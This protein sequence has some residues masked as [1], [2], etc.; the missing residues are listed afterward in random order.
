MITPSSFSTAG[1]SLC[2]ACTGNTAPAADAGAFTLYACANCGSWS[3]DALVRGATTSFT[4]SGYFDHASADRPR[5]RD[6]LA[7]TG[8]ARRTLLDVGCGT[9]AF[10]SFART[11]LPASSLAGIELDAE[12]AKLARQANPDAT[13]HVGD[14]AVVSESLSGA[15]DLITLWDVL[16]HVPEPGR[17]I[18]ALAARLAPGGL[19]FVQT[20]HEA[21]LLPRLGRLSYSL[22]GGRFKAGIRRTHDAHHLVFFTQAGLGQ[23]AASGGLAVQSTWFDRLALARMDGSPLLTWP[24][25]AL[26]RVENAWGNGLFVNALLARPAAN[27]AA[28]RAPG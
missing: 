20:I 28:S 22:T 15:F 4:P 1:G 24:A 8:S 16:E 3:S 19:L 27:A 25:A 6:L 11:Q 2:P 7:R 12:R 13:I 18:R 5:W 14:A 23:L 17:L 26:M 10:L 9:G 21:S